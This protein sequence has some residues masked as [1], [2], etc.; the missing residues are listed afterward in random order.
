MEQEVSTNKEEEE[1]S[2]N[3]II[4]EEEDNNKH[5][6]EMVKTTIISKKDTLRGVKLKEEEGITQNLL[7]GGLMAI[8]VLLPEI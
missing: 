6:K 1:D 4:Q 3:F 7:V 2:L 8:K 5:H